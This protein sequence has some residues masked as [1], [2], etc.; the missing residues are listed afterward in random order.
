MDNISL[1]KPFIPSADVLMPALEKVLYSGYIAEGE[2]VYEFEK[3]F[4][5]YIENPSTLACSSGTSCFAY[6]IKIM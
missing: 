4:R 6:C 3:L 1:V 5:T 2:S